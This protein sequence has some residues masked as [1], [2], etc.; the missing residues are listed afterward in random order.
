MKETLSAKQLKVLRQISTCTISGAVELFDIQPRNVG[1]LSPDIRC[2]F[3]ELGAMV[4]YAVTLTIRTASLPHAGEPSADWYDHLRHVSSLPGPKVVVIQDQDDPPGWVGGAVGDG[5][6][7]AYLNAG[8]IGC[9]TNGG[10]RDIPTVREMKFHY[11]GANPH[12]S[13]AYHHIV[14]F[15]EP[16]TVG[17]VTIREGNLLHGDVHGVMVIPKVVAPCIVEAAQALDEVEA[18]LHKYKSSSDY[19]IEGARE[20]GEGLEQRLTK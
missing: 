5:M 7:H 11:F 12:V 9:V 15:G 18:G 10:L 19:M 20:L 1:C 14:S 4:G 3:P 2:Y 8:A 6:A 17:G 16:V 13:H